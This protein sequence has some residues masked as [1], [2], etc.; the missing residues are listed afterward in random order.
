M[1]GERLIWPKLTPRL[2]TSE[3]RI[4]AMIGGLLGH[5]A[6]EREFLDIDERRREPLLCAERAKLE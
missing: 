6:L 3:G 1:V 2:W 5:A 4:V